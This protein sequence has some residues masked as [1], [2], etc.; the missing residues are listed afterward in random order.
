MVQTQPE[1]VP[2][3]IPI[4]DTP[5]Q[6]EEGERRPAT[7]VR[8]GPIVAPP[9]QQTSVHSAPEELHDLPIHQSEK[10]VYTLRS[11][12]VALAIGVK[13]EVQDGILF[14][15]ALQSYLVLRPEGAVHFPVRDYGSSDRA[16]SQA[17][18]LVG[19]LA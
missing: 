6:P 7:P 17:R 13:G 1:G 14:D 19:R 2:R 18:I 10:S 8:G 11:V 16:L 12:A 4:T 3:I 9:E 5:R 15:T